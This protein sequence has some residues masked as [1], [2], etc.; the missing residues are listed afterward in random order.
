MIILK[1]KKWIKTNFVDN[2][3]SELFTGVKSKKLYIIIRRKN[4]T[5]TE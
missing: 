2:S 5:D 3:R 1:V 4:K